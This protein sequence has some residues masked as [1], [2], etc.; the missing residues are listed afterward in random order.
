MTNNNEEKE[1]QTMTTEALQITAADTIHEL[2]EGK[3][4]FRGVHRLA[5]FREMRNRRRY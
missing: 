5:T 1:E 4:K 2:R 3:R